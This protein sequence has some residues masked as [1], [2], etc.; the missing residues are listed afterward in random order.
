M[1]LILGTKNWEKSTSGDLL[2]V[3][4]F[5]IFDEVFRSGIL[6][7]VV[8]LTDSISHYIVKA[9][10]SDVRV[11]RPYAVDWE[12]PGLERLKRMALKH[13]SINWINIAFALHAGNAAEHWWHY[14]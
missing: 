10:T 1:I 5:N 6:G 7:S 4:S 12:R 3:I 13:L 8:H 9:L 11:A 2:H 14:E